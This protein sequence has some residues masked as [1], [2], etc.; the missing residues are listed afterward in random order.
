MPAPA[1]PPYV[2][3]VLPAWREEEN[4]RLLLPRVKAALAGLGRPW[5]VLVVDAPAPIDATPEIC[6]AEGVRHVARAPTGSYGD[7]FRTALREARGELIACMDADGSHAPE[8]LPALLARAEQAD[9]V[10][11]SR[12]VAGG[13]T[14]NPWILRAMSR[15]V[16]TCYS[17]VLALPVRD[18]SNSLRVYRADLVRGLPLTCDN[19]D[20]IEEVLVQLRR[21][22]PGLRIVEVPVTFRRR[23]FGETK[24]NL[25]AF[26]LGFAVTL[27]RLRLSHPEKK[28]LPPR[29]PLGPGPDT[30]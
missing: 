7:A 18:V 26:A 12:Y 8:I 9:L 5:E 15:I 28:A 29:E 14:E 17:L 13:F 25:V 4:L 24:R 11:G 3:V 20:V 6:R 27:L 16:N 30:R 10:I 22:H 21:R 23:M 19:F 1:E 2:S